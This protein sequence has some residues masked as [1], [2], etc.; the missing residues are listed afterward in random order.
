MNRPVTVTLRRSGKRVDVAAE[1]SILEAV[2][3]AGVATMSGCRIGTCGT[4]RVKVVGGEAEHRDTVLTDVERD[5]GRL[6]CIC[7]SRANGA[8]LT[9]DL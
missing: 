3:A 8:E 5:G 7:V 1:Q 2:E 9:L 4:C 6:M